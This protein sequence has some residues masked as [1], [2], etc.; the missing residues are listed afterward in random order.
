MPTLYKKV[1][2]VAS[3]FTKAYGVWSAGRQVGNKI[4]KAIGHLP[5]RR[6]DYTKRRPGP[7]WSPAAPQKSLVFS[8]GRKLKVNQKFQRKVRQAIQQINTYQYSATA[9]SIGSIGQ[10][11]Y[12]NGDLNKVTDLAAILALVTGNNNTTKYQLLDSQMDINITNQSSGQAFLRIYEVVPRHDVPSALGSTV[13][14]MNTGFTDNGYT[15]NNTNLNSTLFQSTSFCNWFKILKVRTLEFAP[16]QCKKISLINRRSKVINAEH[17]FSTGYLTGLHKGLMFQQWGQ[18]V[19]DSVN[20]TNVSTDGTKFD[21][22]YTL[23]YHYSWM[24]P[25]TNAISN[26]TALSTVNTAE[27]IQPLTG[28]VITDVE[29]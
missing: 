8:H 25:T 14:I 5:R 9:C 20:K 2:R 17:L 19:N 28:A 21:M 24:T 13:A 23:R 10:C 4:S 29:A 3:K 15:A 12:S 27:Y 7:A 18:A 1:R 11:L 26:T 16:G 6:R 22:V